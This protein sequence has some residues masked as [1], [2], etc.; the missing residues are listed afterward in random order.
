MKKHFLLIVSLFCAGAVLGQSPSKHVVLISIDGF[1]PDFYIEEKWPAPYLKEMAEKGAYA[2]GVRGV[3]PSVTY[4]SHT[5]LITGAM[6]ANHGIYYNS[7]FE[8]EG[9]TGRWYWEESLIQTQ[10][11]WDAVREA[12]LTSASFF[13]P[14]SVGAPVDYNV[15]EVWS[16]EEGYGELEVTRQHE[17]PKGFM[18]ELETEVAG[19]LNSTTFNGDYM[20]REDRTGEMAA[21]TLEKYKPNFMTVHLIATDHFQ[22]VEGREGPMVHKALAAADRAVGKMVEAAQRAGILAETTFIIAGDHGFVDIHSAFQPNYHLVQAGLMEPQKDRG[23][24]KATWHTS[25]AAAFLHL[26]DPKD[27]KTLQQVKEIYQN[28]PQQ[29]KKL[30]RL[31]EQEEL[32]S[33]GADPT[34]SL[35]IAPVKG[36]AI[37]SGYEAPLK[38]ASGGTHGFFPDSK[39]IQTG[40]IAYGAGIKAGVVISL[41]GLEDVAP[42]ISHLLSLSFK[43]KDGVFLPGIVEQQEMPK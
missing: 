5:T 24:W 39:D 19:K 35:A 22:H 3:F 26:K 2:Q 14:V 36:I 28:L 1:R 17:M 30:F 42:V 43:V 31:V 8:P 33:I 29:Y 21:Y 23:N 34:I 16:P 37:A 11:L 41:M 6:P 25:G 12:G 40:F 15:P 13:W 9:P 7:P 38:S 18:A 20:N 4:P 32:K 10:T 27:K